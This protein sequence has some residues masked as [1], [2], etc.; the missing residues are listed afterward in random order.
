LTSLTSAQV[1]FGSRSD[2]TNSAVFAESCHLADIDGDGDLDSL[3]ASF[4]DD[5]IAWYSN[6]NGD[7]TFWTAV[8]IS[9]TADG[10]TSVYAVDLDC[11]GD[12]DVLS[13]SSQD[14]RIVWYS[15]DVGDGSSW[16]SHDIS[17]TADNAQSVF[18]AD[19]DGDNDIDV[20]AA[21][22][23]I[24]TI[25]WY[26]NDNGDG[27]AWTS[28][29]VSNLADFA[30]AVTAADVDGD[31]DIDI[32]SASQD[33]DTIAWYSND[34]GD[35]STW[36]AVTISLTADG[37][38][39]LMTGDVDKDGDVDVFSASSNDD[40]IAVYRNTVGD[41][42]VWATTTIASTADGARSVFAV[43]LD[44]DGDVDAMSASTN[45][46]EITWYENT[47]GTGSA[48]VT[49][50][51]STA[52]DGAR[53]IVAGDIDGD[54]KLDLL[55]AS[56][57]DSTVGWFLNTQP[58][59]AINFSA[60][61][62]V[63][64]AA[65]GATGVAAGDVDQDG[66]IDV[67][68]SSATNDSIILYE[69]TTGTGS[70]WIAS[71]ISAA[72]DGAQAVVAA[73]VDEDGDL[74][75]LSASSIDDRIAWYENTAGDGSAWT[76][77]TISSAANGATAVAVGDLDS[78]GTLDVVSASSEDDKIAWYSNDNGD[79]SA[80]TATSITT[81][82]DFASGVA[83]GDV[84]RDCDLDIIAVSRDDNTVALYTNDNG[85][86]SVWT[87]VLI[88]TTSLGVTGVNVGDIDGD[89][90]LDVVTASQTNDTIEW[91]ENLVGDGS[92]WV[93]ATVSTAADS[94][95]AVAAS[96]LD[97]D[98]DVDIVAVSANDDS[99]RWFENTAGDG[100]AW[101]T[102]L[103]SSAADS[104][105]AVA[106][107]DLDKD[108][109]TD[110]LSAS[111]NDNRILWFTSLT[112]VVPMGC[113][114]NPPGS[115]TVISGAP[116]TGTTVVFGIDNPLGT[117][118]PGASVPLL[119]I[120]TAP[121]PGFPCGIPLP[122]FGMNGGVGELLVKTG[123][124]AIKPFPIGS[125]WNGPGLPASVS[126]PLPPDPTLIGLSAFVQGLMI[127]LAP[128][129]TVDFGL[130]DGYRLTFVGP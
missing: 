57:N 117:Q 87:E 38:Q 39:S 75:A 41:G 17:G 58:Q 109:D 100:S 127:D 118:T 67:F 78:D 88:S 29:V 50:S 12:L 3:S 34:N 91:H 18:A 96:D 33:D 93:S 26:S 68:S 105:V 36:T 9:T 61:K 125:I 13:A 2:I 73:D 23:D 123:A 82:A 21:A 107:A 119:I 98:G 99:V 113:G 60:A 7:G 15:N 114:V 27:S 124:F 69:N 46:D 40:R 55:T 35:G 72:A 1:G 108:G 120:S 48:W 4:I 20:I 11:D 76:T 32:L 90:D 80:W 74:D 25:A 116:V 70:T 65:T 19:V 64:T 112:N 16:T 103:I 5:K 37:A 30:T 92:S 126:L 52:V 51:V 128:A 44:G 10:A 104:A 28:H 110:V 45:D 129:A 83:V 63:T 122:G 56:A 95:R 49:H 53:E 81:T 14:D 121:W 86:G 31:S 89:G 130:S 79:G 77:V 43:D 101:T 62:V 24:D 115:I 111:S 97:R 42:S 85:D 84:N 8:T 102:K 54:G 47:L 59:I 6:D 71:T 94:A 66:D 22:A 106:L